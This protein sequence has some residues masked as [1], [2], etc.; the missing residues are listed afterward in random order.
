M[1]FAGDSCRGLISPLHP[2][3]LPKGVV[4]GRAQADVLDQWLLAGSICCR[5]FRWT[6]RG[7][8]GPCCGRRSTIA[9]RQVAVRASKFV[10]LG[11]CLVA[12]LVSRCTVRRPCCRVGCRWCC[13]RLR[14]LQRQQEAA[15]AEDADWEEE[16]FSYDFSQGYT[17][18][19]RAGDASATAGPVRRWLES[20]RELRRRRRVSLEQEEERQV[21][22]ILARLHETG[23][24]G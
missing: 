12:W 17:S 3:E 13:W 10:A 11:L 21:D 8:C 7:R 9:A 16:L 20:R 1:L 23:M 24:K 19:E 15:R 18:L 5:R 22:E 14:L 6:E 2:V 4:V